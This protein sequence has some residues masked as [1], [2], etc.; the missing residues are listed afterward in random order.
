MKFLLKLF[1]VLLIMGAAGAAVGVPVYR[2][3]LM[4]PGPKWRTVE[5]V[6]GNLAFEVNA[7]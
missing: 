1:F 3:W 5:V 6:R 2:Y 4:D 7:T